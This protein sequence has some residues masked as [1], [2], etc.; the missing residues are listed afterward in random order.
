MLVVSAR[1]WRRTVI[2][3]ADTL[4]SLHEA[5]ATVLPPAMSDDCEAR[6][7]ELLAAAPE[8]LGAEALI[9]ATGADALA[10]EVALRR[11]WRSGRVCVSGPGRWAMRLQPWQGR[12]VSYWLRPSGA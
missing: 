9:L 7:V 5:C 12:E 6:I 4:W 8:P 11:L 10:V 3:R 1:A 2:R